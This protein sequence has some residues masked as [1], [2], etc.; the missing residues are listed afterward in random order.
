MP[1]LGIMRPLRPRRFHDVRHDDA[2]CAHRESY[3]PSVEY[4]RDAVEGRAL[5]HGSLRLDSLLDH[6]RSPRQGPET[7][8]CGMG[9]CAVQEVERGRASTWTDTELITTSRIQG[10][11]QRAWKFAAGLQ[12]HGAAAAAGTQCALPARPSWRISLRAL[13]LPPHQLYVVYHG[14][15]PA[16]LR[17]RVG[18]SRG[19][20]TARK[21]P[22]QLVIVSR[23]VRERLAVLLILHRSDSTPC[24]LSG[25]IGKSCE[26]TITSAPH[27][28]HHV[29]LYCSR[30]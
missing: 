14:D 29:F 19:R 20:Q 5:I 27:S 1:V 16:V 10:Q 9:T 2:D 24:P 25:L 13:P 8:V 22:Q 11:H 28:C 6:C 17:T 4:V 23:W 26:I 7:C 15:D 3:D 21:I 12:L 18:R 30:H